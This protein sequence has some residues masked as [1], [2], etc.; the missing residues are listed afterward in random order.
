MPPSV[1][2]IKVDRKINSEVKLN[3]ILNITK[4]LR[5]PKLQYKGF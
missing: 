2:A 4:Y 1:I 3:K 5:R